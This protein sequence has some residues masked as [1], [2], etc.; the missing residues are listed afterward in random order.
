[1][2]RSLA[3]VS[4]VLLFM[5]LSLPWVTV[6]VVF[7]DVTFDS[8]VSG[9][10]GLIILTAHVSHSRFVTGMLDLLWFALPLLGLLLGLLLSA[11]RLAHVDQH[12]W[13]LAAGCHCGQSAGVR[14]RADDIW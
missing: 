4:A 2:A 13:S 12:I 14:C 1:M 9:M 3:L 7:G 5:A 8:Q 11:P 6:C 10:Q